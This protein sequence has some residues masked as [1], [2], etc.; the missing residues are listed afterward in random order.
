MREREGDDGGLGEFVRLVGLKVGGA[1]RG[2]EEE[3]G[4]RIGDEMVL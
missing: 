1:Q 3:Q 2:Q 4:R